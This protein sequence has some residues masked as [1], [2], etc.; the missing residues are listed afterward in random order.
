MEISR[1]EMLMT[2]GAARSRAPTAWRLVE[3]NIDK[4]SSMF[5]YSLNWQ[6]L[7]TGRRREGRYLLRTNLTEDD[8]AVLWQYYI[9]LVAVEQAFKNLKGDLAIRPV[10]HQDVR[11]IEAHVFIAF[12]AY[13]LEV[14]LAGSA[15]GVRARVGCIG[16]TSA[17]ARRSSADGRR[18]S[19]GD[20]R[21]RGR[22]GG[23][24]PYGGSKLFR[25][26]V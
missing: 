11:R 22:G 3:I 18:S 23:V 19:A 9:Q 13:C 25:W 24:E 12:L 6:G 10:L 8:P 17:R 20:R 7:R 1:E 2:L 14:T 15:V 26:R 5:I 21:A 4:E 16:S